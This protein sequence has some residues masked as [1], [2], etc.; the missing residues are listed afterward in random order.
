MKTWKESIHEIPLYPSFYFA[1]STQQIISHVYYFST[2]I[3]SLLGKFW[4][5]V[6]K[7]VEILREGTPNTEIILLGLLPRDAHVL[8]GPPI[9]EWPNRMTSS[10]DLVNLEFKV[11][12]IKA[13]SF[14]FWIRHCLWYWSRTARE[15]IQRAISWKT[16]LWGPR[17]YCKLTKNCPS[18]NPNVFLCMHLHGE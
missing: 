15:M 6:H 5:R 1:S 3:L 9:Y 14:V 4:F 12:N 17:I 13:P 18:P 2:M 7:I 16:W 11:Q 8:S 10:L